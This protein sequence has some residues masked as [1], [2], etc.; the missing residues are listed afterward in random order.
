MS[1]TLRQP[2]PIVPRPTRLLYASCIDGRGVIGT[3]DAGN[4]LHDLAVLPAGSFPT[5]WTT[6][7]SIISA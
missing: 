7:T 2:A 6:I 4:N 1:P 5:D 3:V